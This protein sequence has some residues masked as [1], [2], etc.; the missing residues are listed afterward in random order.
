M[1]A[2]FLYSTFPTVPEP[3]YPH[4]KSNGLLRPESGHMRAAWLR[5]INQLWTDRSDVQPDVVARLDPDFQRFHQIHCHGCKQ[6]IVNIL[7]GR[8]KVSI[9]FGDHV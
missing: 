8:G 9:V 1:P 2:K 6:Q 7:D 3:L 4:L 5:W